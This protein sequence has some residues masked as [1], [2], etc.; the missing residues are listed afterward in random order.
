[1]ATLRGAKQVY[2]TEISDLKTQVVEL[3]TRWDS[4]YTIAEDTPEFKA[5]FLVADKT[6]WFQLS[7]LSSALGIPS[8]LLMLAYLKWKMIR[9]EHE[10]FLTWLAKLKESKQK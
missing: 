3:K 8:V 1:M 10:V 9:Y 6:Q 5:Y 4:L 2:D 7:H